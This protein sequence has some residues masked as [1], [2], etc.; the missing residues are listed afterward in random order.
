MRKVLAP[1][2]S[3]IRVSH[4]AAVSATHERLQHPANMAT[5]ALT[6]QDFAM[7]TEQLAQSLRAQGVRVDITREDTT[8]VFLV[9]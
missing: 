3:A 7:P 4:I 2:T 1:L 5:L 9:R 6:D 8:A